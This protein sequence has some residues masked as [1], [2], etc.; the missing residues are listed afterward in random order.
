MMTNTPYDLIGHIKTVNIA[1]CD[2][3]GTN[4]E[5]EGERSRYT[6][7]EYLIGKG[8]TASDDVIVCPSCSTQREGEVI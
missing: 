4:K 8:W 3:C 5:I 6:V 1:T 7:A 2:R